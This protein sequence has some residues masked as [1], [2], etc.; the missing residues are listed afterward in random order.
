MINLESFPS[1]NCNALCLIIIGY[2]MK[3]KRDS[4]V[5]IKRRHKIP[6]IFDCCPSRSG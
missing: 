5:I 2:Q 1:Q 4:E 6:H 3:Q